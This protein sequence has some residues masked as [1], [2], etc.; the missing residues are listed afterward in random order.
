[1]IQYSVTYQGM[2]IAKIPTNLRNFFHHWILFTAPTHKL[3]KTQKRVLAEMLYY[4]YMLSQEVRTEKLLEKLLFETETRQNIADAVGIPKRRFDLILAE[5]R[6][7]KI[8]VGLTISPKIIP[9]LG[10]GD[11]EFVL[12]FKF[13]I[14]GN[15]GV[16]KKEGRK[17]NTGNSKKRKAN[18]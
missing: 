6:K 15:E 10:V 17:K 4:R 9:Q 16:Y 7:K 3:G 1:M 12:A 18:V 8:V 5:L 13:I 2:K 14:D 11:K